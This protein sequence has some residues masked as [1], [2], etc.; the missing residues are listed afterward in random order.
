[1]QLRPL[2]RMHIDFAPLIG[3][4]DAASATKIFVVVGWE[5]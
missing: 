5:F 3:V 2:P 1:M 4:T